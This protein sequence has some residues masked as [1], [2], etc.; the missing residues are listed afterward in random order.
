MNFNDLSDKNLFWARL[1]DSHG[2]TGDAAW[3]LALCVEDSQDTTVFFNGECYNPHDIKG[4]YPPSRKW[5][6]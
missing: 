5:T 4:Q 2:Y 1:P 3:I 6:T